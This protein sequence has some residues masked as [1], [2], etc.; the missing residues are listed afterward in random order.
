[1][2]DYSPVTYTGNGST[3]TY[4]ITFSDYLKQSNVTV[5]VD[6]VLKTNGGAGTYDYTIDDATKVITFTTAPL[7][8]ATILIERA[9]PTDLSTNEVEFSSGGDFSEVDMNDVVEQSLLIDQELK[10]ADSQ[11]ASRISTLESSAVLEPS[12]VFTTKAALEANTATI[13]DGSWIVVTGYHEAGDGKFGPPVQKVADTSTA[14]DGLQWFV[15]AAGQRYKRL[16]SGSINILWAGAKPEAAFDNTTIINTCLGFTGQVFIPDG[17]WEYSGLI[18]ISDEKV[19]YG[20]SQGE[21]I[22]Q[23]THADAR[24]SIASNSKLS[25]IRIDGDDTAEFGLICAFGSGV[26]IEHVRILNHI[27]AGLCLDGC[28]NSTFVSLKISNNKRNIA[29]A[30]DARNNWFLGVQ[31]RYSSPG[32]ASHADNRHIWAG[33]WV[34]AKLAAVPY[35]GVTLL[36]N[37]FLGCI[38]ESEHGNDYAIEFYDGGSAG[39]GMAFYQTEITSYPSV[40]AVVKV[41]ADFDTAVHFHDCKIE[42][43]YAFEIGAGQIVKAVDC[44]YTGGGAEGKYLGTGN[45]LLGVDQLDSGFNMLAERDTID[46]TIFQL[47]IGEWVTSGTATVAYSSGSKSLTIASPSTTGNSGAK[48]QPSR[49][50]TIIAGHEGRVVE[51]KVWIENNLAQREIT[52]MDAGADTLTLDTTDWNVL[53]DFTAGD[54]VIY[55]EG[56]SAIGGLTNGGTYYIESTTTTTVTLEETIGGGVV[57][58]TSTLPSGTHYLEFVNPNILLRWITYDGMSYSTRDIGY[59]IDGLNTFSERLQGDEVGL[60]MISQKVGGQSWGVGMVKPVI[61]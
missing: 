59:M 39:H 37:M 8:G 26:L 33:V 10:Y 34:H 45:L 30:N 21:T 48:V 3:K 40:T 52:G 5:K 43:T 15:D 13:E 41:G 38:F 20:S 36:R 53:A 12:T 14:G 1:M 16:F 6:G 4:S 49:L 58:I 9:T 51:I 7:N 24:V 55:R 18:D 19:V 29:L 35:G 47:G 27:E 23:A 44:D 2:P 50:P 61:H 60:E 31:T 28:Q 54:A 57:D 17:T 46:N 11:L 32:I 42:G 25:N 22:L 56:D